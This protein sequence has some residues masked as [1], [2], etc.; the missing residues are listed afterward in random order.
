MFEHMVA[1]KALKWVGRRQLWSQV[2][3]NTIANLLT[4]VIVSIGVAL[5]RFFRGNYPAEV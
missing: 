5:V 4:A 1:Y 2:T 3:A